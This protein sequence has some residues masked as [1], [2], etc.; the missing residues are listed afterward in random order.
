MQ[1]LLSLRFRRSVS[2]LATG[3][4]GRSNRRCDLPVRS[5]GDSFRQ[6]HV[7]RGEKRSLQ[8]VRQQFRAHSG[9]LVIKKMIRYFQVL[10]VYFANSSIRIALVQTLQK[11]QFSF[12]KKSGGNVDISCSD[13]VS[14]LGLNWS[15][16]DMIGMRNDF[17]KRRR[18]PGRR[19]DLSN[20]V[21]LMTAEFRLNACLSRLR[22]KP[23]L[24]YAS[25]F[26]ICIG[27]SRLAPY[28][29][30][31]GATA[32]ENRHRGLKPNADDQP[33]GPQRPKASDK[34]NKSACTQGK[35]PDAR[36]LSACQNDHSQ[37]AQLRS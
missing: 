24:F 9:F 36:R 19:R 16:S 1:N 21:A 5:V 11:N 29:L 35:S 23:G 14:Y 33:I 13:V 28:T 26:R 7:H 31:E 12:L 34:E 32:K 18:A 10:R 25:H 6:Q 15:H 37:K 4:R 2:A 8:R 20:G 17:C 27:V 3:Y 22:R 30:D